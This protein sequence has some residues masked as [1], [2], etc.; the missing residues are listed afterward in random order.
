VVREFQSGILTKSEELARMARVGYEKG[1]TG[2]LEVLEA[3]RTLRSA[4]T[5]YYSALA[6]HAKSLAQ[7]EWA[8][9]T[10]EVVK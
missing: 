2:Y 5:D 7:L 1:A 6:D 10:V 3:Q 4:R 8:T 9:G